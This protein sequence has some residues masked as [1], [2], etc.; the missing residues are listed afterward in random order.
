MKILFQALVVLVFSTVCLAA[1]DEIDLS[2]YQIRGSGGRE[3]RLGMKISELESILGVAEY[4]ERVARN[5]PLH[6]PDFV[7]IRKYEGL[8]VVFN[9]FGELSVVEMLVIPRRGTSF[10]F[11]NLQAGRS[12]IEEAV[13]IYGKPDVIGGK[14]RVNSNGF[15]YFVPN[16]PEHSD[17]GFFYYMYS[18]P[19]ANKWYPVTNVIQLRF[20]D[21]NVLDEVL[22]VIDTF[23]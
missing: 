21:N 15:I 22:L 2:N 9:D 14:I 7:E 23:Y 13:G 8:T 1:D 20:D 18:M 4:V 19:K 10:E 6:P 11:G 3:I 16:H 12:S 17:P 5:D